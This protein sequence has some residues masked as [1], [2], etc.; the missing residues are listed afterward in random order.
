MNDHIN[1]KPR[2]ENKTSWLPLRRVRLSAHEFGRAHGHGCV[3]WRA[4]TQDGGQE[5]SAQGAGRRGLGGLRPEEPPAESGRS[6]SPRCWAG[7][8]RA[9]E[10]RGR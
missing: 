2:V 8:C 7:A 5:E 3:R 1:S 4:R 6:G 9:K 10:R